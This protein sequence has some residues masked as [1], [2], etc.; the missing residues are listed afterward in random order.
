MRGSGIMPR[1]QLQGQCHIEPKSIGL[2]QTMLQTKS[3]CNDFIGT[4]SSYRHNEYGQCM[5]PET[6]HRL[7]YILRPEILKLEQWRGHQFSKSDP[8][9]HEL[10]DN[11]NNY[12]PNP[13]L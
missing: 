10:R 1:G 4:D 3:T 11:V 13:S 7:E 12:E 8:D 9:Y 6:Q 5:L 2:E